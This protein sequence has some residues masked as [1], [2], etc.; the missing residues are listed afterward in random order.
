M[1]HSEQNF[2][3][4]EFSCPQEGHTVIG[5]AYGGS[6]SASSTLARVA[7]AGDVLENPATG[8]R[9]VFLRYLEYSDGA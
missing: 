4:G 6:A 8:E 5:L 7:R 2:A 1:P 9:L 3:P